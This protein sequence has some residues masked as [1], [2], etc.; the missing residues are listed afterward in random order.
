MKKP[1]PQSS[2]EAFGPQDVIYILFKHKWKIIVL[3]LLGFTASAVVYLNRK[4]LYESQAKLLVRYV[5]NRNSVDP[6]QSQ[7]NPTGGPGD[8]IINTEIEILKSE[9]LAKAVAEAVGV[10]KLMPHSG[11]NAK[12]EDAAGLVCSQL[13]V[14]V[15]PGSNVVHINYSAEDPELSVSVLGELVQQY[16]IK[17]LQIHRSANAFEL[18]SKQAE[19]VEKRL[20]ATELELDGLRTKSGITSLVEATSALS[21]QRA[22]TQEDL[23]FAKAE[24]A[25]QLAKVKSV[26][27]AS[28]FDVPSANAVNPA[29]PLSDGKEVVE[30]TPVHV[31]G[32]YKSL[33][34]VLAVLQK[35]DFELRL[36]FKSGNRLVT[37]NDS[38]VKEY[39]AKRL[40]L[41][42]QYPDL[43]N[44]TAALNPEN[45]TAQWSLSTENAKLASIMARLDVYENHLKE[46]KNQFNE[47]YAVGA[48]IEALERK[49][50]MEDAEF[51]SLELN[52]KNAKVDQT[53]DPSR[54]P[55]ITM[56]Q[57]PSKPIKTYDKITQKIVLGLAGIGV[58]MGLGAAF[59]IELLFDRRIKRPTE[60]QARL[61][62][63]LLLSIP[64]IRQRDRLDH[65]LTNESD[66][67]RLGNQGD[68]K[69]QIA[70]K[71]WTPESAV[72]K[73]IGFILPYS[74]TI[75]D[76]IIF[77]FEV[78]NI[79]HKPKLVAVTGL[80]DG[81]G[82]S[83]IA[84]GLAKSFSEISGAKVLLVDL[85][86]YHPEES[87]IFG[88]TPRHSLNGA[89]QL[90]RNITFKASRQSL[91]YASATAR[92]DQTGLTTFSPIHLY[93]LMP[94]LQASDFDY[95][96]FDM[97]P[98]DQTSRTLTMAGLMDKI[99]LVLDAE[100]T[101]RDALKWGYSEL[102]KG[103][104]DVS[105][106]FNKTRSHAP[107]WL[108]GEN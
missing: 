87:E 17:H 76:R 29:K 66:A 20:K 51:R 6:F 77:N 40:A 47:Q 79:T 104:A 32:E 81:A 34:D 90:A 1:Q 5:L 67:L 80:S 42:K 49:R 16:F 38:Q 103:R 36:K 89:L 78:N 92:R 73:A 19:E 3:S 101:S 84:A 86:S 88:E 39:E 2:K 28:G 44:E 37:L 45:K 70:Q 102:V 106:I 13:S 26:K 50:Q 22:R 74:E 68:S 96:I 69:Q 60:I 31:V 21:T 85:S 71:K 53:L 57:Q 72:Q 54:M 63:P 75:R 18:V 14:A 99:L 64:F 105:C 11:G 65:L 9:D 83:T 52:L 43:I 58:A 12:I 15:A 93:E 8:S 95:I 48:K 30:K 82:A 91:Y 41:V 108:T 7:M 4:P 46:I 98:I 10:D 56:V 55:N 62:L 33:L 94:Q 59:L 107:S 97:P 35:R 100:N 24:L 27:G 25:E 61:Q 23:M